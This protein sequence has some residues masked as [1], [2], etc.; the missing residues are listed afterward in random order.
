MLFR[1]LSMEFKAQNARWTLV[2]AAVVYRI[3]IR[4]DGKGPAENVRI[5]MM[6]RNASGAQEQELSA[7]FSAPLDHAAHQ[8]AELAPGESLELQGEVRIAA[9]ELTPLAIGSRPVLI[10]VV[11]AKLAHGARAI[12]SIHSAFIVGEEHTPPTERLA[13]LRMDQGPRQYSNVGTRPAI[14]RAAA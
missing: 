1:S 10:P 11:A 2:G 8:I 7:W 13:P 4:N 9:N 5:A 14:S 12:A 3:T 6:M